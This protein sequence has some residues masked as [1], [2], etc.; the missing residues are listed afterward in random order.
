MNHS[1]AEDDPY[2][3]ARFVS[4]QE[5]VYE[6]ALAELQSGWKQTHWMWFVFPQLAGLGSSAMSRRYA[7]SGADEARTYLSHPVLGPRLEE[8]CRTLLG[9]KGRSAVEIFGATD[10]LKLRSCATLYGLVS[11]A[12]SVFQQV[13]EKFFQGDGDDA[14]AR[15]LR[16]KKDEKLTSDD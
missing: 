11:P 9:L 2:D 14:T 16:N 5:R 4:A 8:C 10:K 13:L 1:G 7:I 6:R 12:G 3:L 15:L